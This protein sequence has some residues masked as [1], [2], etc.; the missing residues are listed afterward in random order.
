MKKSIVLT[1]SFLL[2]CLMNFSTNKTYANNENQTSNILSSC[3][4]DEN[5]DDWIITGGNF[6][7]ADKTINSIEGNPYE[8]PYT[9]NNWC[10]I[11]CNKAIDVNEKGKLSLSVC[12]SSEDIAFKD[13]S[14]T[15]TGEVLVEY[16]DGNKHQY[17]LTFSRQTTECMNYYHSVF[18]NDAQSVI[19]S[20]QLTKLQVISDVSSVGFYLKDPQLSIIKS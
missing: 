13:E 20:V 16:E 7:K 9:M 10:E 15:I 4:W 18:E 1:I 11:S 5:I 17:T 19:K 3:S 12:I 8:Y 14:V 2:A 6:N